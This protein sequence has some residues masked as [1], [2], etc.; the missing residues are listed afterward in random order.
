MKFYVNCI[1]LVTRKSLL[2]FYS[3]RIYSYRALV[4]FFIVII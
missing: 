1:I 4:L 3:H 2:N